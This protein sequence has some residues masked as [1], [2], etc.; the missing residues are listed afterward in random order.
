[1]NRCVYLKY[2]IQRSVFSISYAIHFPPPA[3]YS[4]PPFAS[5]PNVFRPPDYSHPL[6]IWHSRVD[7]QQCWLALVAL[8]TPTICVFYFYPT[9]TLPPLIPTP[10]SLVFQKL[11]T[12]PRLFPPPNIRYSEYIIN[13]IIYAFARHQCETPSLLRM[14]NKIPVIHKVFSNMK[15]CSTKILPP[16]L[17]LRLL[18]SCVQILRQLEV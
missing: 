13:V 5:F 1:M 3:F 17:H 16:L 9:H 12:R 8:S 10:F 7:M 2:L 14:R 4:N 11:S 15:Q 18:L 6:I